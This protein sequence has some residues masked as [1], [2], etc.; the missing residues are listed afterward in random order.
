MAKKNYVL[1]IGILCFFGGWVLNTILVALS[2]G[3]LIRE[4]A[5]LSVVVGLLMLIIGGII[6]QQVS[7]RPLVKKLFYR[8]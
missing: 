8:R 6:L 5:R 3:G 4:L 1:R 2:I 7:D